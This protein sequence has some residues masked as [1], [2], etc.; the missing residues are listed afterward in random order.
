MR[1]VADLHVLGAARGAALDDGL[2]DRRH[3]IR[4]VPQLLYDHILA[5]IWGSSA[6]CTIPDRHRQSTERHRTVRCRASSHWHVPYTMYSH[7]CQRGYYKHILHATHLVQGDA[8]AA[9]VFQQVVHIQDRVRRRLRE[10]SRPVETLQAAAYQIAHHTLA[11]TALM[12]QCDAKL[13][14]SQAP[15]VTGPVESQRAHLRTSPG[16][17]RWAG[18]PSVRCRH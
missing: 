8:P 13:S 11:V 12:R 7:L 15:A 3:P 1:D 5:V 2:R 17:G 14:C 4:R 10:A 9:P 16:A 6:M 18:P